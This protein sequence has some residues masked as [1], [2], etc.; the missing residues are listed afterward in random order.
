MDLPVTSSACSGAYGTQVSTPNRGKATSRYST[1]TNGFSE[2]DKERRKRPLGTTYEH[3]YST[4][5]DVSLCRIA[6]LS[7]RPRLHPSCVMPPALVDPG[8]VLVSSCRTQTCRH[9][10]EDSSK[11]WEILF[12]SKSWPTV[13]RL[14][15][16][17]SNIV[18]LVEYV[19][20]GAN[21]G[22]CDQGSCQYLGIISSRRWVRT[23]FFP[24]CLLA[25]IICFLL[26]D[27]CLDHL[28]KQSIFYTVG[29]GV[30]QFLES[31]TVVHP[32]TTAS[33]SNGVY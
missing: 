17:W 20:R 25:S 33:D 23:I 22:R 12:Q 30:T 15:V 24:H 7:L 31:R 14:T 26:L 2:R 29:P 21:Q 11:P 10:G 28:K 3:R 16:V 9:I 27:Y 5:T 4:G 1:S 6:A 13:S 8:V 19:Q 18:M 32:R